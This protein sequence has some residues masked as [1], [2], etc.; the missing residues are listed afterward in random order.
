MVQKLL[1]GELSDQRNNRAKKPH[2]VYLKP[3][4]KAYSWT[5]CNSSSAQVNHRFLNAFRWCYFT[6]CACSRST[7]SNFKSRQL[8]RSQEQL[9][10]MLWGLR[11]ER[12]SQALMSRLSFHKRLAAILSAFVYDSLQIPCADLIFS[13]C[14]P[15]FASHLQII[16]EYQRIWWFTKWR[17]EWCQVTTS[18]LPLIGKRCAHLT[19]GFSLCGKGGN[20]Q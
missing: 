11:S 20:L 18:F 13:P 9:V 10:G 6:A 8:Q 4:E 1:S 14:G 19:G 3:L 5:G 17:E 16:E 15:F 12:A 7:I 2:G